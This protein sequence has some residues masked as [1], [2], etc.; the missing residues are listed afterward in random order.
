[1]TDS[2]FDDD[3]KSFSFLCINFRYIY[4]YINIEHSA[5]ATSTC[6][7]SGILARLL[8]IP[9]KKTIGYSCMFT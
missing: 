2:L 8:S 5:E 4:I 1:M 6:E 9:K 7:A 3:P